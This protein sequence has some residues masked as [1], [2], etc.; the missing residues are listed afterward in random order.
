MPTD[1][2][3]RQQQSID[4]RWALTRVS[5]ITVSTTIALLALAA[6]LG[7]SVFADGAAGLIVFGGVGLIAGLAGTLGLVAAR[8]LT[9]RRQAPTATDSETPD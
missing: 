4:S 3:A 2:S 9:E 1:P 6:A 5:V 8:R 7:I